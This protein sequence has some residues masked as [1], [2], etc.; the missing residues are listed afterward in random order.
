MEY[1]NGCTWPTKGKDRIGGGNGFLTYD[2]VSYPQPTYHPGMDLNFGSGNDDCGLDVSAM[3][4]GI[5]NYSGGP[6]KGWG[7]HVVIFHPQYNVYS[8]YAHLKEFSV[9]KGEDVR[10]G[11]VFAH[12]GKTGT[13][14]CHVHFEVRKQSLPPDYWPGG[15]TKEEVL[16]KYYD[17]KEFILRHPEGLELPPDVSAW[18][19]QTNISDGSRLNDPATRYEVILMLYRAFHS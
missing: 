8:H 7:N 15:K 11:Q 10:R 3:A 1:R 4:D 17:P 12:V 2:T 6:S 9:K 5:V 13:K 16:E 18:I 14:Y 19:K